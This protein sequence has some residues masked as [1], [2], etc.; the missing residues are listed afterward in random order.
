LSEFDP[1]KEA[2]KPDTAVVKTFEVKVTDGELTIEFGEV[3]ELPL[4]NGIEVIQKK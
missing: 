1:V 4:I 2:G 3:V